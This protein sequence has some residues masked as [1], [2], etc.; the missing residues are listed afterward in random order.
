MSE[1]AKEKIGILADKLSDLPKD[2]ADA[3]M[4]QYAAHLEGFA[5]GFAAGQAHARKE[6]K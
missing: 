4:S 2:A 1:N 5:E 6:V 3:A